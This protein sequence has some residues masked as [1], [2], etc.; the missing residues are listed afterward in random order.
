M[1]LEHN[2]RADL[3][4]Q[5]RRRI[6]ALAVGGRLFSAQPGE[7]TGMR[8]Q[9]ARRARPFESLRLPRKC[10]QAVGVNHHRPIQR[11]E[12]SGHQSVQ[13]EGAAHPRPAGD[14]RG[15]AGLAENLRQGA[16]G[17][18]ARPVGNKRHGHV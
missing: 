5:T 16:E 7:L 17:D 18:P 13:P 3:P 15:L 2:H 14:D 9:H 8:R 4:S 10:V 6:R 1:S 12:Q 11:R